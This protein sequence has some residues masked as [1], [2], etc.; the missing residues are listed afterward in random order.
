MS[1]DTLQK[2]SNK[3]QIP[4]HIAIQLNILTLWSHLISINQGAQRS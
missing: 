3:G 2:Y 1:V 4:I